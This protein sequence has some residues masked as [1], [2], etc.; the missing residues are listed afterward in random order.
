VKGTRR[1]IV[2]VGC[3][4]EQRHYG[5][6]LCS[7]CHKA[8][9]A[10]G[11]ERRVVVCLNCHSEATH[12]GRGLCSPCHKNKGVRARFPRLM[13]GDLPFE[14]RDMTEAELDAL[15]EEQMACLPAWWQD[16]SRGQEQSPPGIRVIPDPR[17][18]RDGY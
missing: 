10:S 11:E 3:G 18:R 17:R 16:E 7:A 14:G 2:C 4:R 5:R 8:R 6:G 9:S 1:T 15:I 13:R 12:Q